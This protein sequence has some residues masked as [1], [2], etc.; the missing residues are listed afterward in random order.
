MTERVKRKLPV[1]VWAAVQSGRRELLIGLPH[2][3]ADEQRE[4]VGLLGD[5]IEQVEVERRR[6]DRLMRRVTAS[7]QNILGAARKLEGINPDE[8]TE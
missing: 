2:L 5:L 3:D 6:V 7:A 8:E 4:L 1:Q